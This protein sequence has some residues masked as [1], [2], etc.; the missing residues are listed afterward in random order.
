[1]AR[2]LVVENDPKTTG[3]YGELLKRNG[4]KVETVQSN[5]E[6]ISCMDKFQN[7]TN[8]LRVIL[9]PSEWSNHH[10]LN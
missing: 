6:A 5:A 9:S 10:P 4:H 3:P 7:K 1:M 8:S 2:I